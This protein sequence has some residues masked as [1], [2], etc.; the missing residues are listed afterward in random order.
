MDFTKLDQNIKGDAN[1][2]SFNTMFQQETEELRIKGTEEGTKAKAS[3]LN[4]TRLSISQKATT[5]KKRNNIV[6]LKSL[7]VICHDCG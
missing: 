4:T 2:L 3:E 7:K 5:F 6:S 1:N